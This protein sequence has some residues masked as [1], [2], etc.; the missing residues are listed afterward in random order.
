MPP[1]KSFSPQRFTSL[2]SRT[3]GAAK[4]RLNHHVKASSISITTIISA[5]AAPMIRE[6]REIVR[7]VAASA[8]SVTSSIWHSTAII[9]GVFGT[10]M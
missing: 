9:Y 6:T 4:R 2:S 3:T 5:S 7:S 1:A 10:G 8:T